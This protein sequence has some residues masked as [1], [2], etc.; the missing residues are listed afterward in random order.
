MNLK[1]TLFL[2]ILLLV[3][4]LAWLLLAT[5]KPAESTS[6]TVAALHDDLAPES[7]TRIE[8][9]GASGR[10]LIL[11][12]GGPNEPWS[13]PGK[14]PVRKNEVE[15]L[16]Q[17]ITTLRSRFAPIPA[18]DADLKKYGL[19]PATLT[20]TVKA[21]GTDHVV[22]LGEKDDA[23][24]RFSRPTYLRLDQGSEILRLAPGLIAELD[25]QQEY[26]QQRRL[27][28]VERVTRDDAKVEQ[29]AAQSIAVK[30][31]A[32]SFQLEKKGD[33]WQLQSPVK[34]RVDPEKLK[35]L[36]SALPD[37][38]AEQFIDKKDKKLEDFGL[39]DPE[40]TIAA[41]PLR[42][43]VGKQSDVKVRMVNKPGP[44]TPF[45][46]KS[47]PEIVHEEYRYAK[48]ADNDQVFEIKA[49]RLKDIAAEVD[50]L[51]D[52]Q[53]ARF[54]AGDVRRLEIKD[55]AGQIVLAKD[56]DKDKW[57]LEKPEALA[58]ESSQVTELL[59]KL[60]DLK[61]KDKDII[62][63]SDPKEYGLEPAL[64]TV[65]VNVEETTGSGDKK[66]TTAKEFVIRFG[67]KKDEKG[68]KDDK[69]KLYAQVEGWPRI[70]AL[71]DAILKLVQ[72]P[73]L[74]YR[75]RRLLDVPVSDLAKIEIHRKGESFTLEQTKGKWRLE[76]PTQAEVDSLK[77]DQIAGD[78]ARLEAIE[79]VTADP[80]KD[81]LETVYGLAKPGEQVTLSFTD[82]K[83]KSHTLFVGKQKGDKNEF[84]ARLDSGPIFLVRKDLRENLD[85]D[86]LAYRPLQL[87]NVPAD[88]IAELAIQKDEEFRLKRDGK[89]WNIAGPFD[90]K[91]VE[92]AVM[93]LVDDVANL[94]GEKFVSHQAKD[95][96]S[97]GLEKP[98][99]R[100][101][102]I[103]AAAKDAKDVKDQPK[104]RTLLVGK[105]TEKDAKARFA[106]LGDSEAIFVLGEK[107]VAAIDRG[108]L[109]FL[110]K[111][112]LSVDSK[113]ID[114]VKSAAATGGF[115]L[116]KDKDRWQVVDSPAPAFTADEGVVQNMLRSLGNL[117]AD[118]IAAYGPKIDWTTYGLD[119]PAT[120]IQMTVTGSGE[121]D[122]P[123]KAEEHT[124]VL[125]K[126]AKPGGR[127]ARVDKKPEVA[128]LDTATIADLSRGYLDFVNHNVLQYDQDTVTALARVMDGAKL[129]IVKKGDQWRIVAPAERAADNFTMENL[130]DQTFR[131]RAQRI[132]AY[133][134][135]DLAAFGLDKPAA[136]VVFR[137]SGKEKEHV[138]RVGKPADE[139][140][141]KDTGERYAMVDN[142]PAIA[143]LSAGL[144]K[145]LTAPALQFA[146]RNIASFIVA[147]KAVVDRG[148]RKL[149]F[150]K[151]DSAWKLTAPVKADAESGE[152]DAFL[153][154]LSRLRADELVA[155]KPADLKAYGLDTP[156]VRWQL[157]SGD[158]EVLNL[159]VGAAEKAKDKQ[160]SPRHYAK[161]AG[162]D[163]VF[164]LSPKTANQALAEY[165]TRKPWTM[166]A[167][168]VDK[169]VVSSGASSFTL[170][171]RDNAWIIAGKS[172]KLK[173][174]M[175]SETLDA[176]AGLKVARY[177]ADQKPDLLLFGLKEPSHTIELFTSSGKKTL[178][179]GRNE[180]DTGRVYA[181]VSGSDT[182]FVISATDVARILRPLSAYLEETKKKTE[183]STGG[184]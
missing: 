36:L 149:Q 136:T 175:V 64:A 19:D 91:A 102:L 35:T 87:W 131:L 7:L 34:D 171:K 182:V 123:A 61:V 82:D 142:G 66:A 176:L 29:L 72:R 137:L 20:V 59:D 21:K 110:D 138:I 143:V 112:L 30:A 133:P 168:Q 37:I 42:L 116:Q 141:K 26:Y 113:N 4:G 101:R 148:P 89:N 140:G 147:D 45:G 162:G 90:A 93:P 62:D 107:V 2:A 54:K 179:I 109:D 164:L 94:R 115:T 50:S 128:I 169:I 105:T 163:T 103:P 184:T 84:Y 68:K 134:A 104:E 80:K 10:K 53:L 49:D 65:K 125:G 78:L 126:E 39:K 43:L 74:A 170:E 132:A 6:A 183:K 124:I 98:Y 79:F 76:K 173:E 57:A 41:G 174:K 151:E 60:A 14:W 86:S 96:T 153:K 16:V 114:K 38:W 160:D 130:F 11:E 122:K 47:K 51:R 158:K 117:R 69:G 108:P 31:P 88:D 83:K 70:N 181:S 8:I 24:N 23:N 22:R 167:A 56:K 180:G 144:S 71:D 146:D 77:A 139:P 5:L 92:S 172:D 177:V 17:A 154:E 156:L 165:R 81:D 95:L 121:K 27:F 73:A 46:P 44:Q 178:L 111:N 127:Y 13:L 119:K 106:R 63:K 166:D 52:P 159:L 135:K 152:L 155:E 100:L 129:D 12:R 25:K 161:L 15:H 28:P 3:G 32:T 55:S 48:L 9:A 75:G 58:A 99:L 1:T 85:R 150:A 18:T 145:L 97:Y 40:Y 118:K 67:A 120:T 157:Q 33:D